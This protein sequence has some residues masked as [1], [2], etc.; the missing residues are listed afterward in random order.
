MLSDGCTLLEIAT[1]LG[2]SERTVK[3]I[4]SAVQIRLGLVR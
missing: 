3:N 2:Y 4:L 1:K